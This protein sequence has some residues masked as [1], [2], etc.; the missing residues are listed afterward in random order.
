MLSPFFRLSELQPLPEP[1]SQLCRRPATS[2]Y[3]R[4]PIGSRI[5]MQSLTWF[6][7]GREY[8]TG[9]DQDRGRRPRRRRSICTLSGSS[10]RMDARSSR[11]SEAQSL[12]SSAVR[13]QPTQMPAAR[14]MTQI[15]LHGLSGSTLFQVVSVK[16]GSPRTT[17]DQARLAG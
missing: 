12:I 5:L 8:A 11:V 1:K 14:W 3:E 10:A 6:W 9:S 16:P 2:R 13:W 15:C 17:I 4:K 7:F